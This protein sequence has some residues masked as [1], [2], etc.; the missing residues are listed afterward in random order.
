VTVDARPQGRARK[1]HRQFLERAY[2]G[3]RIAQVV[4][5]DDDGLASDFVAILRVRIGE[6]LQAGRLP[7]ADSAHFLT[8]P[9]GYGLVH[10]GGPPELYRHRYRLINL[11][12]TMVGPASRSIHAIVHQV[13]PIRIGFTA[14]DGLPMF[15]RSVH[16][17]NDSRVA[18]TER[19]RRVHDWRTEK[20]F[21]ARFGYV[22]PLLDG[23]SGDRAE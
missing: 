4:L 16:A 14:H 21:A 1:F 12:L 10:S 6:A 2:G 17:Y 13:D 5:D 18:V 9:S 11:G 22:A 23:V 19:W 3:R 15:L 7:A 20:G 8:F